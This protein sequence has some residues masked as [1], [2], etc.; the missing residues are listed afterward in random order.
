MKTY[1]YVRS[2]DPYDGSYSVVTITEDEI[3]ANWWD[4]WVQKMTKKYGPDSELITRENCIEDYV[5]T[6]WAFEVEVDV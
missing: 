6:H 4:W 3:I 1:C 2:I 5:T